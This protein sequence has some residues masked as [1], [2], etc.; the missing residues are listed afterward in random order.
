MAISVIASPITLSLI[1]VQGNRVDLNLELYGI[2][3]RTKG[4]RDTAL[5]VY[6]YCNAIGPDGAIDSGVVNMSTSLY[7]SW[8]NETVI[9]TPIEVIMWQDGHDKFGT[10]ILS[11]NIE[12]AASIRVFS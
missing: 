7:G 12:V 4:S 6:I 5:D 1:P 8:F 9:A 2:L 10:V 3:Q 11:D